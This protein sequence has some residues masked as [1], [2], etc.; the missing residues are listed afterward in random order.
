MTASEPEQSRITNR[1]TKKQSACA[2]GQRDTQLFELAVEVGT[3]EPGLFGNPA[4]VSTLPG[5]V[6]FEIH[7]LEG[8]TS[9]AKLSIEAD[10]P[11]ATDRS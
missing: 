11:H 10:P 7:A 8:I 2:T 6:V 1:R 3:L 5:D 4:H 9:I